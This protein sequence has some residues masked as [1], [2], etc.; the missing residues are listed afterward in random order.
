MIVTDARGRVALD[1]AAIRG[2][3]GIEGSAEGRTP[4]EA[5]R[6]GT[7]EGAEA[8]GFETQAD[9]AVTGSFDLLEVQLEESEGDGFPRPLHR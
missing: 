8:Y 4:I 3:F 5:L 6:Y 9:W 2:L 1:N 7:V